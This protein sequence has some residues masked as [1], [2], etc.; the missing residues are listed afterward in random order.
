M[1][2]NQNAGI[3]T[4]DLPL[5]AAVQGT[6]TMLVNMEVGVGQVPFS[7]ASEFFKDELKP[8]VQTEAAAQISAQESAEK[9]SVTIT[10]NQAYPFNAG[11]A[12]VAL[13]TPRKNLDYITNVEIAAAVGNVQAIE[14][15][16]K[17]LNGFKIRYDGSATSVTI[18]YYVTGGMQ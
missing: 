16:D 7:A 14:V 17:Q 10:N 3:K 4:T 5:G 2:V 15:Y 9:G 1:S 8:T 12:T 6:D 18:K 13:G 11:I